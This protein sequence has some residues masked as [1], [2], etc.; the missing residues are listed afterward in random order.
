MEYSNMQTLNIIA[1]YPQISLKSHTLRALMKQILVGMKEFHSADIKCD[2]ILLHSPPG[3]GRV[4]VKIADFGLAMKED[5]ENEQ[6]YVAGT[7]PYWAQE[8]FNRHLKS[9]FKVD[10]YAIGITFYRIHTNKY[11]IFESNYEKQRQKIIQLKNIER[12]PELK[13]NLL[14]DLL[15]KLLEFD[16]NKRITAAEALQHPYFTSPEALADVS[17]EQKDLA[18]LAITAQLEGN[19]NITEFD[20]DPTYIVVKT[21][22]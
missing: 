15:S 10:I 8:F 22:S 12:P 19:S 4:Y 2:N 20:K 13:D 7:L 5:L 9:T 16:P 14:W 21:F 17:Q 3:S 1:K 11:P 6:T 18:Q